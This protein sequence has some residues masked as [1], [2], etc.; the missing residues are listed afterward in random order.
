MTAAYN[1]HTEVVKWLVKAGADPASFDGGRVT[2]L[3]ASRFGGASAEQTAYLEAKTYC[4]SL[5]CS[6]AGLKKCTGCKQARYCG[7]QCQLLH[8]PAH[9]STCKAHQAKTGEEE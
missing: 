1:K 4:S 7:E 6:G 9:K 2:A 5:G 3:D 8:W